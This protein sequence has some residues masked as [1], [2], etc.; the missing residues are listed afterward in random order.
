MTIKLAFVHRM[1]PK[2][3]KN[4]Y[5]WLKESVLPRVPETFL[6][7]LLTPI[8]PYFKVDLK[9]H[10]HQETTLAKLISLFP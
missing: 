6:L 10:L 1:K 2:W 8:A 7:T 4:S 3:R 5:F 9:F